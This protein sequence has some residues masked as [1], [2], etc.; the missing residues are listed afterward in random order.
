MINQILL[1]LCKL[2]QGNNLSNCCFTFT[3]N[4]LN[5]KIFNSLTPYKWNET[6]S[7]IVK[8]LFIQFALT[9]N[10]MQKIAYY[11]NKDKRMNQNPMNVFYNITYY[12]GSLFSACKDEIFTSQTIIKFYFNAF[13]PARTPQCHN[14]LHHLFNWEETYEKEQFWQKKADNLS[15]FILSS[16]WNNLLSILHNMQNMKPYL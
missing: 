16:T 4:N 7:M 13:W 9:N 1:H 11:V 15:E 12:E 14:V 8:I 3:P 6:Y 10:I 2:S 5:E